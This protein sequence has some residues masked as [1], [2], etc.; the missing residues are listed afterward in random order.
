M[1]RHMFSLLLLLLAIG[2]QVEKTIES[3][4]PAQRGRIMFLSRR[5][6]A[7]QP[8]QLRNTFGVLALHDYQ[9]LPAPP[10]PAPQRKPL[11][12]QEKI[13]AF[14]R[15]QGRLSTMRAMRQIWRE[16]EDLAIAQRR[17]NEWTLSPNLYPTPKNSGKDEPWNL[18]IS[19]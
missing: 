11:T 15:M 8:F 16:H 9:P 13:A 12:L 7:R 17:W 19:R 2:S 18:H 4:Q 5:L 14:N 10:P 3:H 6:P 1:I